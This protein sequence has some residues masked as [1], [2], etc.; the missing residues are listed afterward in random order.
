VLRCSRVASR[1]RGL[2]PHSTVFAV[3]VSSLQVEMQVT[4]DIQ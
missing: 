2:V 1:D 3:I 4:H